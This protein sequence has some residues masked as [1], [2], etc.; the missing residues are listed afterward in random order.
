MNYG[1]FKSKDKYRDKS[2][3][4]K[5]GNKNPS[6]E[7]QNFSYE[8]PK[9]EKTLDR[10][11]T[12]NTKAF[13][14][15]QNVGNIEVHADPNAALSRGSY[16]YNII[17][18][19]NKVLDANYTGYKNIE[20]NSLTQLNN[21]N[22]SQLLNCFDSIRLIR[23]INY[24][25]MCYTDS[26]W[27]TTAT[28][29]SN[30]TGHKNLAMNL[31]ML[32]A[33]NEALSTAYST[34]LTQLAY[35]LNTIEA[36][37]TPIPE[38]VND[39]DSTAYQNYGKMMG[40]IHYQTVLQNAVS[41]IAKY[42]QI[43]SLEQHILNMSYRREAPLIKALFGLLK[44][45]AF[46]ATL[47]AIGT[48]TIGEYFDLD[49]MKQVNTLINI[50]S[51]KSN[52]MTDPLIT[53]VATT[54]IPKLVMKTGNT[55]TVFYDS[56]KVLKVNGRF[57]NPL[58]F[59]TTTGDLD[60]ET[61]VA[62]LNTFLDQNTILS[63]ARKVTNLSGAALTAEVGE[64]ETPSQYY[65]CI[66]KIIAAINTIVARFTTEVTDIRTFIDKMYQTRFVY[67]KKGVSFFV[68][69]KA[70]TL[71]DP[72]YNVILADVLRASVGGSAIMVFDDE[73]LRWSEY[74]LWNKYEGIPEFDRYSG[75]SFISFSLRRLYRDPETRGSWD[76]SYMCLPIIF[77]DESVTTDFNSV[78]A[79]TRKGLS[80]EITP[81]ETTELNDNQV[82]ARLL[83]L[84]TNTLLKIPTIDLTLLP[85]YSLND[86]TI[87]RVCSAALALLLNVAGYGSVK[88]GYGEDETTLALDP[89]YVCYLDL[90]LEDISNEMI[91]YCRNYSP[92][93]VQTP[94]GRRTMGFGK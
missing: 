51:R 47:N 92:F 25:Y 91:Q 83:P 1:K 82:L 41:P 10:S 76:D 48:A 94:D 87:K 56:D 74:T 6:Y 2:E 52:S 90:Q 86:T 4:F 60:F 93:R 73:T 3:I 64:V 19:T 49:W 29:I 23:R 37:D 54:K 81:T 85:S 40:L 38:S 26:S 45:K 27:P 78:Y 75:G 34:M 22:S 84:N 21:N 33:F 39:L 89:D 30:A 9:E 35:Y 43:R 36:P 61:L 46:I 17:D 28:D 66:N 62:Y 20:G 58:T 7:E 15:L 71:A 53:L 31:E 14:D 65:E 59:Q 72:H 67:W 68:D 16:P 79:L 32:K 63:W 42:I 13:R 55:G 88:Y 11:L 12:Y 24:L 80:V 5:G 69:E 44:K 77:N 57:T 70:I 50:P 18:R 8:K